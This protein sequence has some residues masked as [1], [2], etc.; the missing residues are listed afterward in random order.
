MPVK[1]LALITVTATEDVPL[2]YANLIS[3]VPK[4]ASGIIG[5]LSICVVGFGISFLVFRRLY[6]LPLLPV[7]FKPKDR[8]LRLSVL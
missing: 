2:S 3:S 6:A 7:R 1:P 4:P 8:W 5:G